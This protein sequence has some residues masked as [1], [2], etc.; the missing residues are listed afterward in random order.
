MELGFSYW[1]T[2][3]TVFTYQIVLMAA[4]VRCVGS[5]PGPQSTRGDSIKMIN[6]YVL[7]YRC[8]LLVSD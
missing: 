6:Q 1:L 5:R 7:L 3:G 8:L 4:R 2:Q